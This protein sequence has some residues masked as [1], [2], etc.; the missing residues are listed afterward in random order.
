MCSPSYRTAEEGGVE[1]SQQLPTLCLLSSLGA[2]GPPWAYDTGKTLFSVSRSAAADFII[3]RLLYCYSRF[4]VAVWGDRWI[5]SFLIG[6]QGLP[7]R[8]TYVRFAATS[9]LG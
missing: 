5:L 2:C 4:W 7:G 3:C 1:G 6:A 9:A 8:Q